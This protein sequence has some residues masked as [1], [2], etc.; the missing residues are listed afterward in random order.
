M[1][2]LR[3]G[4]ADFQSHEAFLLSMGEWAAAELPVLVGF[5]SRMYLDPVGGSIA[6]PIAVLR[7][8]P[9]YRVRFGILEHWGGR[10]DVA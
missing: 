4:R 5:N 10:L 7:G 6:E 3:A 9:D 8:D 1:A 2:F